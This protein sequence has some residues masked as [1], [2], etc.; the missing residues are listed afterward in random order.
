ME[1]D[2]DRRDERKIAH[3]LPPRH[4]RCVLL[5]LE[6]GGCC[7]E[8]LWV[9]CPKPIDSDP[10]NDNQQGHQGGGGDVD[11]PRQVGDGLPGPLLD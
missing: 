8:C 11:V 9:M 2:H 1:E 7:W 6:A 5:L 3:L 10:T 4:D